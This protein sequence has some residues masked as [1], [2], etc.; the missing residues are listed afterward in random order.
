MKATIVLVTYQ[1]S[2]LSMKCISSLAT[3]TRERYSVVWVDNGSDF[4]HVKAVQDLLEA[5]HPEKWEMIPLSKNAGFAA[6]ANIGLDQVKTPY[7]VL[8]N[9]DVVVTDG[10]LR[11]L[12][13][14]IDSRPRYALIGA[15]TDNISSCQRYERAAV[16]AGSGDF[17]DVERGNV[18]YF[19]VIIRM[20]ALIQ[21]GK[22]DT[23]FFNG[24]E[25][26]D[27]NDRLRAAGWKTGVTL[28]SFVY[29]KHLATR[30]ELPDFKENN[31][32]NRELL[33]RKREERRLK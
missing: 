4:V 20:S 12:V 8:L 6:A 16:R 26:D 17:F 28:R 1:H 25:D 14:A 13:E 23:R 29:H 22:M 33:E 10:W 30:G 19:C 2:D 31:R 32:R 21:V 11:G 3:H 7:A 5:S 27:L 18:A 24:G 15:T 9:N